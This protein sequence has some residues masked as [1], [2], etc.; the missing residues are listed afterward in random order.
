MDRRALSVGLAFFV[1]CGCGGSQRMIDGRSD[2][3]ALFAPDGRT[4]AAKRYTSQNLLYIDGVC[5][6]V[7]IYTY[8][9][10]QYVASISLSQ[11]G[12]M[13]SDAMGD[14]FV[15]VPQSVSIG[16]IYEYA[17]G[18]TQPIETLTD[19]GEP[20]GCSVDPSTGNL[21]VANGFAPGSNYGHANVAIYAN[22]KG[23]PTYYKDTNIYWYYYCAYDDR[24]NLLVNGN[25][26][27]SFVPYAI[28]PK[29]A[30]TFT[31]ITFNKNVGFGP[32]QWDGHHFAIGTG[33]LSSDTI[34]Q[35]SIAGSSGTVV[36]QTPIDGP[37]KRVDIPFWI[38]GGRVILSFVPNGRR[39]SW[40]GY[41]KYPDGGQPQQILQR[42]GGRKLPNYL[43]YGMLVSVAPSR[44]RIRK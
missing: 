6:G 30:S 7:C 15:T 23:A 1:L 39:L 10:G 17:H 42:V 24:G 9:A 12:F 22:A 4:Q 25:S 18:Q 19:A 13:C 27:E 14:V 43:P 33:Y 5:G 20:D 21:A 29:G 16:Y 34:D 8:P 31:D 28:L 32:I 35:V 38:Q 26:E 41:W 36:G 40:L 3:T 37:I 2:G 44:S 11:Y